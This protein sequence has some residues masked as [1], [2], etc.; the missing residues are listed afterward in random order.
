MPSMTFPRPVCG[1]VAALLLACSLL[2]AAAPQAQA[3]V[4]TATTTVDQVFE[5]DGAVQFTSPMGVWQ[6]DYEAGVDANTAAMATLMRL[7]GTGKPISFTYFMEGS[8]RILTKSSV[9]SLAWMR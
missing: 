6:L 8:L 2:L 1:L 9:A 7:A 5:A 4:L 3:Q